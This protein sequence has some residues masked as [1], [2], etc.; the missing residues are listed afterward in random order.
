MVTLYP[1]EK[2]K[3]GTAESIDKTAEITCMCVSDQKT[4]RFI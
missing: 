4:T 1:N 3:F 2:V